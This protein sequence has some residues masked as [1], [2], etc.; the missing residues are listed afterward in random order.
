MEHYGIQY[1]VQI[2]MCVQLIYNSV[3]ISAQFVQCL[4]LPSEETLATHRA[5]IEGSYQTM[6]MRVLTLAFGWCTY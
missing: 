5:T 1:M 6:W 2:G 3:C 4:S